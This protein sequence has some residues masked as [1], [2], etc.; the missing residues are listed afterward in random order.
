LAA[1]G[2][3]NTIRFRAR[4]ELDLTALTAALPEGSAVDEPTPG[5]YVVTG[6]VVPETLATLTAWCAGQGLLPESLHVERRSLE[7]V[8][9]EL[10]G[11]ELRP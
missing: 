9:L 5:S 4:A 1:R 2:A 10:T 8:F 3:E 11:R 6:K 7:D